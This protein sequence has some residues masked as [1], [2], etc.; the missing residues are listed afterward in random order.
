MS[1]PTR[2]LDEGFRDGLTV[3]ELLGR[4]VGLKVGT[5]DVGFA[6][7]L[8]DVGLAEG[9]LVDGAREGENE[10]AVTVGALDGIDVEGE[11]VG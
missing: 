1:R 8:D 4:D 2:N 10:G 3:G 7:G 11:P 6:V 9:V 5:E